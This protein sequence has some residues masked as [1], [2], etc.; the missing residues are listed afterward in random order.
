MGKQRAFGKWTAGGASSHFSRNTT[1]STQTTRNRR[2]S[3]LC[4][5]RE[6]FV[7]G[8]ITKRHDSVCVGAGVELGYCSA[9][10]AELALSVVASAACGPALAAF[11]AGEFE[12]L[13]ALV[14]LALLRAHRT[15]P[16]WRWKSRDFGFGVFVL[17]GQTLA[18]EELSATRG[19]AGD[20]GTGD[21]EPLAQVAKKS[22]QVVFLHN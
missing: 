8:F 12:E 6:N 19:F 13:A 22:S 3:T 4:S 16:H 5:G 18:A 9:R 7:G 17:A 14:A 11:L 1:L 20:E 15:S 10:S 21:T 2:Q